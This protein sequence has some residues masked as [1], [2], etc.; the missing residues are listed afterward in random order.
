MS[1]PQ[2]ALRWLHEHA[3]AAGFTVDAGSHML[4]GVPIRGEEPH[5]RRSD[6]SPET[7]TLTVYVPVFE[8]SLDPD[9]LS[10]GIVDDEH[11]LRPIR[12][13]LTEQRPAETSI[14]DWRVRCGERRGSI[15]RHHL[16]GS[17]ACRSRPQSSRSRAGWRSVG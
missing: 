8:I 15:Y 11:P 3:R 14:A 2:V 4:N 6:D 13:C 17:S 5:F 7:Y 12:R 16:R 10:A 1:D 9:R